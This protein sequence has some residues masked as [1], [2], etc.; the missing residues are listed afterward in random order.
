MGG[1]AEIVRL[2][3][4]ALN[5]RGRHYLPT[6]PTPE[7]RF[8]RNQPPSIAWVIPRYADQPRWPAVPAQGLSP[9]ASTMA[10]ATAVAVAGSSGTGSF[11]HSFHHGRRNGG[12][13]GWK[14]GCLGPQNQMLLELALICPSLSGRVVLKVCHYHLTWPSTN[15]AIHPSTNLT[16][17]RPPTLGQVSA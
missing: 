12:G 16:Y 7:F 9:T 4:N 8:D 5:V 2:V 17:S 6:N 11:P 1:E 14:S 3:A 15:M 13:G 10:A